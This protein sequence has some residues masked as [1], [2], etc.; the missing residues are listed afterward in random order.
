MPNAKNVI[1]KGRKFS[2]TNQPPN[3]GRKP[4]LYRQLISSC[5]VEGRPMPSREDF[6]KVVAFL[7]ERTRG[8]LEEISSLSDTP[9][10]VQ[11]II[12]SIFEDLKNGR[13]TVINALFDRLFGKATQVAEVKA[14]IYKPRT[15]TKEEIG[16]YMIKFNEEY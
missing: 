8:E 14:D 7:L 10:W 12:G 3:R 9:I 15:L 16:E 13:I 5:E 6:Y 2:S 1:G 11:S 4:S